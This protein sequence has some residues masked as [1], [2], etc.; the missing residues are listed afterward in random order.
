MR[1]HMT[2]HMTTKK[3]KIPSRAQ[4]LADEMKALEGLCTE[5]KLQ[6]EK[7]HAKFC[8]MKGVYQ[9]SA[10]LEALHFEGD[11]ISRQIAA[12]EIKLRRPVEEINHSVN[13]LWSNFQSL[14]AQLKSRQTRLL[15]L[16]MSHKGTKCALCALKK[17][18]HQ[19]PSQRSPKNNKKR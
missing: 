4:K 13:G 8:R 19:W 18:E 5:A 9:T 16:L 17:A 2:R 3:R 6:Y 1:T 7:E 15:L 10:K 14:Q 11:K 12:E